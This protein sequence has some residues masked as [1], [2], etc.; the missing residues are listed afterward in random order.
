MILGFYHNMLLRLRTTFRGCAPLLPVLLLLFVGGGNTLRA[1]ESQ[2]EPPLF[3]KISFTPEE[4]MQQ[5]RYNPRSK[6][7]LMT[8]APWWRKLY[9]GI[10][11]GVLG[12][13][14]NA[15]TAN[16]TSANFAV[17]YKFSPVHSLRLQGA[18][19]SFRSPK[20]QKLESGFGVGV[21]YLAN[22]SNYAWGYNTRRIVDVSLLLGVGATIMNR[23]VPS[24][25]NPYGHI[26]LQ[27][28]AHLSPFFSVVA[29]PYVGLQK[30]MGE[31]LG[32]E[33]PSGVDL[34]YGVRGGLQLSLE[35]RADYFTEADTIFRKPFLE[36]SAGASAPLYG[37]NN[38][39]RVGPLYQVGVGM[40]MNPM[41]GMRLTA[42][43]THMPWNVSYAV[44]DGVN[45]KHHKDQTL[46]GGRAEIL[47]NPLN[48]INS[49]RNRPGGN[50]F[51]LNISLGGEFGWN[52]RNG[53][54]DAEGGKFRS[55]YYGLT[56]AMQFM[57]RVSSLG[58]YIYLE[59][60]Y[61][62]AMYDIPYVNTD[63]SLSVSE[64][65]V[66]LSLGTRV[67]MTQ[68]SITFSNNRSEFFRRFWVGMDFGVM[69][70]KLNEGYHLSNAL[71]PAFNISLGY[72]WKTYASFRLALG[73]Q[74]AKAAVRSD[75]AG[76]DKND[77][78]FV[79][80]GLWNNSYSLLDVRLGYLLNL[81][82]LLQGH[83]ENRRLNFYLGV[84]PALSC[85]VAETDNWI[86]GQQNEI[87]PLKYYAL[88]E[89]KSG[90]LSMGLHASLLATL[91][92]WKDLDITAETMGQYNFSSSTT[93]AGKPSAFN[94][95]Y[96]YSL[97][98][99]YNISQ[100]QVADFFKGR[101]TQPWQKG[102]QMEASYGWSLPFDTGAGLSCSGE[103]ADFGVLYWFNSMLAVRASL[104]L[105]QVYWNKTE[106]EGEKE[107]VSGVALH[108]PFTQY[109]TQAQGGGRLELVLNPINVVPSMRNKE[110]APKWELNLSAGL[111]VGK[112]YKT[113]AISSV[114]VG[115]T[116]GLT[117]LYRLSNTAQLFLEPRLDIYNISQMNTALQAKESYTEKLFSLRL[118][119]RISRPVDRKPG[120]KPEFVHRSNRDKLAHRGL[121]ATVHGGL[122]KLTE[123][124]RAS[125][126]GFPLSPS[127]GGSIGYDINRLHSV[128]MQV[129]VDMMSRL[130]PN[131][132]YRVMVGAL[133]RD[134]VGIMKSNYTQMDLRLQ[135][136]LNLTT[137]WTRKD[138]RNPWT[139][140]FMAGPVMSTFLSEKNELA[141]GELMT[142]P[143]VE[144]AGLTYK[145]TWGFGAS[146][147]TMLAYKL[148]LNWD[149]TAESFVQYYFNS[150]YVP[151]YYIS[152]LNNLKMG[153]ALGARFNF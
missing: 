6:D 130:R 51:D 19:Y 10:G 91:N 147:G 119:T 131:Q 109:R 87:K 144:Y 53:V 35:K 148:T 92:V 124:V 81:N 133:P 132:P 15:G 150:D 60:R 79:G 102:L 101:F 110:K 25:V 83:D 33:N 96:A 151:R 74:T 137:L 77:E 73:L 114:Y 152:T 115:F 123:S 80:S 14:D 82:N 138:R 95:K 66:S 153:F 27:A 52:S 22:L 139:L 62:M 31:V 72:D 146:V 136:M 143:G 117:G 54:A 34:V 36:I 120:E 26:G 44:Q 127:F 89:S 41:V 23:P 78:V 85:V 84:G 105:S 47:I 39:L 55:Y 98:V 20:T 90:N 29:E 99:R 3:R 12:L 93:P 107:P 59:P 4:A 94:L 149:L 24:K 9:L 30:G 17:G 129:A 128:R 11:G 113:A 68:P 112:T 61:L 135:Y 141:E 32:R 13:N 97:G 42:H 1:Q 28:E 126:G 108:A 7:T 16:G 65:S 140:Y 63:N 69:R 116:T 46:Y 37:H 56:G 100:L 118:G 45:V 71:N 145:G 121:F 64:N 76:L 88:K 49:W 106:V 2:N 21:D 50:R 40:W 67:Y 125:V 43:S 70:F 103:N 86:E 75:F 111:S 8:N 5:K 122:S 104:G 18:M 58:T 38:S 48:F 134:F 142:G 57:Y